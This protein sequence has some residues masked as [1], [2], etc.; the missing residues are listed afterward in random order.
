MLSR[1]DVYKELGIAPAWR[2]RDTAS[3]ARA[4]VC[5]WEQ[6]SDAVAHCTRCR[7]AATRTQGVLGV[8]DR[9]AD[10]LVV[11]EA[12]GADEDRLGEPFVG[13]AGKLL[14]AMLA[15]IGI[16][17]GDNVYITN[18]LKSRPPGNRDPEADEV[19]ACMPYL[20]AQIDLVK[21]K[22]ILALGRFAA[23][24]LLAT[25]AALGSLRG[26]VHSFQNIPLVVTYHPAYLL[27]NLPD[28]ARAWEDLCLARRTIQRL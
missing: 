4:P 19:A 14:D 22:L 13:K 6:L 5:G 3:E 27:R 23:Q 21:P 10:W 7:L 16:A 18:V 28:K 1:D 15:S 24:S 9:E 17:R 26:R 11:G 2:L 25:D 20:L 8:G 12:P